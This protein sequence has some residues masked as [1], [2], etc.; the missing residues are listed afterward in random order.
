MT[1]M[2]PSPRPAE[3]HRL[4]IAQKRAL[5]AATQREPAVACPA[6]DT[7]VMPA[8]LI[9]HLEQRCTGPREPGPGARWVT[10]R[11]AVANIRRADRDLS[12]PAAMMML[13][14]WSRPDGRGVIAVRTR[15][16]RGDRQYLFSDLAKNVARRMVV[17]G[18][19]KRVSNG[20]TPCP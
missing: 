11:E 3:Y 10:W 15:G 14:R 6:C 13:S 9:A 4:P 17:V 18:T 19:N 20:V 1:T 8:D 2:R 12:E 7:Q 5:A 16:T